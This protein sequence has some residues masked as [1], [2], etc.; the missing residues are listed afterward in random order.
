MKTRKR[1]T[2]EQKQQLF[3]L[4]AQFDAEN[5]PKPKPQPRLALDLPH[6][7]TESYSYRLPNTFKKHLDEMIKELNATQ[8]Y[9][10]W[11]LMK[12]ACDGIRT[13]EYV[14]ISEL[15]SFAHFAKTMKD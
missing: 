8:G 13:S 1:Y 3:I 6:G 5:A 10:L 2:T 4:L 12:F 15:S 11:H 14:A 9:I 7:V